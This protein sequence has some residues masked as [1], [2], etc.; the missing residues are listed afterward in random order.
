MRSQWSR[1]GRPD[2]RA[3]SRHRSGPDRAQRGRA[4]TFDRGLVHPAAVKVA[5]LLPDRPIRGRVLGRVFD[6]RSDIGVDLVVEHGI[7]AGEGALGI[8]FRALVPTAVDVRP[9]IVARLHRQI[10]GGEVHSPR[11]EFCGGRSGELARL[12]SGQLGVAGIIRASAATPANT[13]FFKVK[14][15]PRQNPSVQ[16]GQV[17]ACQSPFRRRGGWPSRRAVSGAPG[18][19]RDRR[20]PRGGS[21][22]CKSRRRRGRSRGQGRF[23]ACRWCR[24]GRRG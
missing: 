17:R 12:G 15:P 13:M 8:D 10:G 2:R 3:S 11:G 16:S 18:A 14:A 24:A 23:Q 7:D 22:R 4:A 1:T 6:D 20:F 5:D 9:E 21:T 19:R